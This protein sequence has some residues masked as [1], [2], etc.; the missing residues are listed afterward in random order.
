MG[1]A[2][3]PFRKWHR[4]EIVILPS[5]GGK[6]PFEHE[7]YA[8]AES[9]A[10]ESDMAVGIVSIGGVSGLVRVVVRLSVVLFKQ[11]DRLLGGFAVV[12]GWPGEVFVGSI[13]RD[14]EEVVP[15]HHSS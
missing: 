7:P 12:V 5:L 4:F 3:S 8:F 11:F 13:W 9:G 2:L 10:G 1:A 15:L 14:S 6:V